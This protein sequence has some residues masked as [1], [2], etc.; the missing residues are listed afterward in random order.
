LKKTIHVLLIPSLFFIISIF[1]YLWNLDNWC[2]WQDEANAAL[3]AKNILK[4]GYPYVFDGH[5]LIWPGL[6]D[7][8]PTSFYWILWGWLPL[9]FNALIFFLFGTTTY[10]ARLVSACAGIVFIQLLYQ[11]MIKTKLP[12]ITAFWSVIM[13]LFCVP[14][15]LFFRQCGYYAFSV[16]FSFLMIFIY[17]GFNS[18]Y[19]KN[20]YFALSSLALLNT[21]LLIW[22]VVVLSITIGSFLIDKSLKKTLKFA[23]FN[24]ILALPFLYLYQ[25]WE[26]F[27]RTKYS[28]GSPAFF[29]YKERLLFYLQSLN[30]AVSPWWLILF[31]LSWFLFFR[32]TFTT[33]EK[34]ILFQSLILFVITII[35]TPLLSRYIYFRY[36]LMLIP[37]ILISA[38]IIS[39]RIWQF[40]KKIGL[41]VFA[42]IIY[43]NILGIRQ[44]QNGDRFSQLNQFYYELTHK[45]N[46]VNNTIVSYLN[47]HA[48]A[49]DSVLCNYGSFP[50]IF[51]TNLIVRGG[52]SG[53]GVFKNSRSEHFEIP[54]LDKPDWIIIRK[55]WKYLYHAGNLEHILRKYSYEKITLNI[56]DSQWGNRPSPFYHFFIT[57]LVENPLTIYKLIK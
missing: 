18:S 55:N 46:D 49:Q 54:I 48:G 4:F 42:V 1:F 10:T 7:V 14:L 11:I 17:Y 43:F 30:I 56:E 57:F 28:I 39:V 41:L 40:Q 47:K 32:K 44:S 33:F 6:S 27:E 23:L 25:V 35:F 52:A 34:K 45:G 29:P 50:I 15:T 2:L 51:Y 31:L 21:H 20:I 22:G 8:S 24:L 26:L 19:K 9:Y 37:M 5:N 36:I 53:V 16:L 13:I 38:S 12:K 3:L